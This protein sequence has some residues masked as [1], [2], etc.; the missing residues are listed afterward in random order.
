MA[1][2]GVK[3]LIVRKI[4]KTGAT[5]C[6]SYAKMNQ[7]QLPLR[8]LPQTS[9]KLTGLEVGR[10]GPVK[11]VK[12]RARK[13]GSPQVSVTKLYLLFDLP[14]AHK[15]RSTVMEVMMPLKYLYY[16]LVYR[17]NMTHKC[18]NSSTLVIN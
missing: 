5:R 8:S 15:I 7:I 12:P 14:S 18:I 17:I 16:S 3:E 9:L 11:S 6:Q 13:V 10:E 2:V 1:I 4:S